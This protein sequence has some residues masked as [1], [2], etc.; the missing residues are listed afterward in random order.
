MRKT[1]IVRPAKKSNISATVKSRPATCCTDILADLV[2]SNTGYDVTSYFRSAFTE[3]RKTADNA[4]SDGFGL[5][6]SGAA[7]CL[8]HHLVGILFKFDQD[9]IG[10]LLYIS[11]QVTFSVLLCIRLLFALVKHAV[12][13]CD[14]VFVCFV[15][16]HYVDS[17][18][19]VCL[20]SMSHVTDIVS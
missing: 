8:P 19:V 7:F 2:Y 17:C 5:N 13:L 16:V 9:A 14:H 18:I 4:A 15:F 6:F 20:T 10:T 11:I 12:T 3:F 1:Y